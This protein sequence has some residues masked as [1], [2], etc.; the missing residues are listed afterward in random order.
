MEIDLGLA[1]ERMPRRTPTDVKK[2]R[3]VTCE[4]EDGSTLDLP[5]ELEQGFHRITEHTH[6]GQRL[7]IHEIFITYGEQ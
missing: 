4:Y 7:V 2:L 6:G 1:K 3:T 5:V